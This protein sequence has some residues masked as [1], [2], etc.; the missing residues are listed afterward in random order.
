M[1]A[2]FRDVW[3]GAHAELMGFE[4]AAIYLCMVCVAVSLVSIVL[5]FLIGAGMSVKTVLDARRR[6]RR[7]PAYLDQLSHSCSV[8]ELAEIDQA[9]DQVLAGDRAAH[10]GVP[11]W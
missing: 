3:P 4:Q 2:P 7:T 10:L 6:S 9:L 8:S 1:I 11:G 5:F